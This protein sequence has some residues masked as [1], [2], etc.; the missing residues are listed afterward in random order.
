MVENSVVFKNDVLGVELPTKICNGVQ[1]F[2]VYSI[3][4]MLGYK[5]TTKTV[6]DNLF[7]EYIFKFRNVLGKNKQPI[8]LTNEAGVYQLVLRCSFPAAKPFQKWVVEEVLPSIHKNGGYIM[9]Q[10]KL[11]EDERNKLLNRIHNLEQEVSNA[12]RALG[13]TG[14]SKKREAKECRTLSMQ[15]R[16]RADKLDEE[17]DNI[18]SSMNEAPNTEELFESK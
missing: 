1:L 9:G 16:D 14:E 18:L 11:S 3:C 5:N 10:E 4:K 7:P 15:L 8:L 6:A 13:M 17:G 2:P 12:R